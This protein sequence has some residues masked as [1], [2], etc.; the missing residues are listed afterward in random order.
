MLINHQHRRPG[1]AVVEMAFVGPVALLLIL[2]IMDLGIAVWSYS[3]ITQAAREGGRYAQ[4]HGSQY[5]AGVAGQPSSAGPV[6]PA[7]GPTA[8]DPNVDQ[9]V[10]RYAYVHQNNLTVQS[11][12]PNGDN[13]PN[14]PVTVQATYSYSPLLF[15]KLGTLTMRTQTTMIINY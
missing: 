9:V 5:A 6:T 13:N 8:N 2:G 15:L 4:V 1:A 3:N 14:S 12:W 11:S 10:R 7:S